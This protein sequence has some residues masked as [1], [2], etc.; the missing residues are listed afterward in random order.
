MSEPTIYVRGSGEYWIANIPAVTGCNAS[1]KTRDEAVANVR[2]SFAEYLDLLHSRG[3]TVE[4]WRG[5]DA[6][7][8]AVAD[9]ASPMLPEDQAPVEEHDLRDFLHVFEAQHAALIALAGSLSAAEMERKPDDATWSPRQAL[10]HIVE[11]QALFLARLEAWPDDPFNTVQSQ[12]RMVAQRFA[13]MEPAETTAT[14]VIQ[15]VPWNARRVMRRILE[16]EW[17]H[18]G[19]LK[20]IVA[21]LERTKKA[22]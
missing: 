7:K 9:A 8:F 21:A 15:G 4:H 18:Y 11:S 1:G 10:E 3:V 19:H 13:V 2:R 5:L 17:E 22:P 14:R 16:H 20:E 12:H 6:S